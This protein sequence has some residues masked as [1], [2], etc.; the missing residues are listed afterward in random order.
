MGFLSKIWKRQSSLKE[1]YPLFWQIYLQCFESTY[2]SKTPIEEVRFVVFDTETTGL[3][4]KEDQILSIGA[5][6]VQNW[7]MPIAD[8]F[9]CFIHQS[10]TP[11]AANVQVHEIIPKERTESLSEQEA[12]I[13]FLD[14]IK[15][16][17]LVAHHAAFD[18]NMMNQSLKLFG[19]FKLKNKILDTGVLAKRVKIPPFP[20][21]FSLD[22]LCEEY[23]IPI[24]DRHNAAGDAYLTGV[25]FLKLLA[26][27]EK[28]GVRTLGALQANPFFQ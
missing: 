3:N 19:N 13:A 11:V 21:S 18:Q 26:R 9:E 10:Y 16:A 12:I 27:L 5:I 17:V 6:S 2:S 22:A 8:S 15:D 23:K 25:L 7:E 14:Y 24:H 20:P 4:I 1:D 28:R